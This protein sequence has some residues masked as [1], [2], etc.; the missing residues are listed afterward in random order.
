MEPATDLISR[1]L[2]ELLYTWGKTDKTVS[3]ERVSAK[4]LH[5]WSNFAQDIQNTSTPK[6]NGQRQPDR[7]RPRLR[8]NRTQ[9]WFSNRKQADSPGEILQ[10]CIRFCAQG[11]PGC[12]VH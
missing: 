7:L 8:P 10:A 4:H 12:R 6:P 11:P 1:P 2:L 5:P 9:R 3:D